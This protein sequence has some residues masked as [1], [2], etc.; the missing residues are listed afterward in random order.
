MG[1]KE[2]YRRRRVEAAI[3]TLRHYKAAIPDPQDRWFP[4]NE[5]IN[6]LIGRASPR[7]RA[8]AR[9]L[10]RNFP[11]FS[12]G[13]NAYTAFVVGRG[14]RFQSLAMRPD[15]TPDER[16]RQLIERR[17]AEW[18][19]QDADVSGRLCFHEMQQLACRS[20]LECGEALFIFSSR[21]E[22]RVNPLCLM[23]IDPDR[24]TDMGAEAVPSE[25]ID[26]FAGVE[27]ERRTGRAV[28]YHVSDDSW[29]LGG[30]TRVPAADVA[31]VFQTLRP[32]Q[33]RGVT[34]L[35][36]AIMVAHYMA[37]YE[38]AELSAARMAAKYMA[39]VTT[40]DPALFQAARMGGRI[41][42]MKDG[43]EGPQKLEHLENAIIEY[44]R[45]G[46]Q[47]SFAQSNRPGDSFDRFSKYAS[48]MVSVAIDVP[49][50]ILSGDYSGINYSTSKASRGDAQ[51]L[52][53]PHKAMMQ[54]FCARVFRRW[55][56]MEA[57][58]QPYMPAYFRRPELYTGALWI[59]SGMPSVDPQ[60]DGRADIDAIA[61]GLASPQQVIIRNGGDPEEVLLDL[62]AWQDRKEALGVQTG[63]PSTALAHNPSA[64]EDQ[65]LGLPED[66]KEEAE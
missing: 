5:G 35:A 13:V 53:S 26:V 31:H 33:L 66:G 36:P 2:W 28:A 45:P 59:P 41:A 1:M 55:L 58:T 21:L 12:R 20:I 46:E 14:A 47:I 39:L 32:G 40:P 8:R 4:I 15:G 24:L 50:E 54:R 18:C 65:P 17:W 30:V 51:M 38:E 7:L 19:E 11:L 27:F 63:E 9:D 57:L 56:D 23:P 48:R 64:V 62:K 6:H 37:E 16:V 60:R 10:V 49:Y 43:G 25:D 42:G 29:K 61:A 44:L 3:R 52:L 22:N 34:P